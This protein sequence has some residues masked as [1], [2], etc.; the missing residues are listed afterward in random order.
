M[1]LDLTFSQHIFGFA[2]EWSAVFC[3]VDLF[4]VVDVIR[5]IESYFMNNMLVWNCDATIS[6]HEEEDIMVL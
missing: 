2:R 4:V 1:L 6:G 5:V 3:A